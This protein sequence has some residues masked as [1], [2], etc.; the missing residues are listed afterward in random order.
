[1]IGFE[2]FGIIGIIGYVGESVRYTQVWR[3]RGIAMDPRRDT[4]KRRHMWLKKDRFWQG[5]IAYQQKHVFKNFW[6]VSN[7][8]LEGL[9]SMVEVF[10]QFLGVSQ[11]LSQGFQNGVYIGSGS[12]L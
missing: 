5:F 4:F 12:G 10:V 2:L 11:G 9:V 7:Q 3:R 8:G 6:K 1:M